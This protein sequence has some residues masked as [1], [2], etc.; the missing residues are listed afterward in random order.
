M[1]TL[2]ELNEMTSIELANH[3]EAI[4]QTDICQDKKYCD[5]LTKI[6]ISKPII[7]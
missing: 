3:I 1:K 4:T 2:N 5:L 7:F 6:F